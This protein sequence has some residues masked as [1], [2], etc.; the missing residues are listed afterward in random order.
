MRPRDGGCGNRK[1]RHFMGRLR[2]LS[3]GTKLVNGLASALSGPS[4][5]VCVLPSVNGLRA[6]TKAT[7]STWFYIH[8]VCQTP[9]SGG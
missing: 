1:D 2:L 4:K 8:F 6:P 5:M 9:I 3:V 7:Q